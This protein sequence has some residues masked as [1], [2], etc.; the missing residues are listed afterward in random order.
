M[1]QSVASNRIRDGH[2]KHWKPSTESYVALF[3]VCVGVLPP[4]VLWPLGLHS[5][6]TQINPLWLFA[7][8]FAISGAR[9]A[10]GTA[11]LAAIASLT[12]LTFHAILLV[13]VAV[14]IQ[15]RV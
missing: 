10:K 4:L 13:L 14:L 6:I 8:L 12:V 3:L 7:W 11:R 15:A 2:V 1:R 5:L 9:R